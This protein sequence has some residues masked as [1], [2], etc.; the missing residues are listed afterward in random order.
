MR[1]HAALENLSIRR[2]VEKP[3]CNPQ[4]DPLGTL[5][6][7]RQQLRGIEVVSPKIPAHTLGFSGPRTIHAPASQL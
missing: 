1:I 4:R 2:S 7:K 3:S 6:A 5:L